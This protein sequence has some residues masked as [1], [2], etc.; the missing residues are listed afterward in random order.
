[1]DISQ[2]FVNRNNPHT[3]LTRRPELYIIWNITGMETKL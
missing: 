1:M 2:T 3:A